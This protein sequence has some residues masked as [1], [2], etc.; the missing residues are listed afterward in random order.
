[1]SRK[2]LSSINSSF[3]LDATL[4]DILKGLLIQFEIIELMLFN[5]KLVIQIMV[6]ITS[7]TV[8]VF[9]ISG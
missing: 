4:I 3:L 9:A 5:M 7:Q 1:M 2:E 6:D 8:M